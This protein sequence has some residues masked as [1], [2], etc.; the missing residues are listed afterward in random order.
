MTEK[1]TIEGTR[2]RSIES[3]FLFY[4]WLWNILLA[5]GL[6]TFILKYKLG[7]SLDDLLNLN[8][9]S[10]GNLLDSHQIAGFFGEKW[11]ALLL[12]GIFVFLYFAV[13]FEQKAA[14]E[15]ARKLF[16]EPGIPTDWMQ[17]RGRRYLFCIIGANIVQFL[18][19]A[20]SVDNILAFSAWLATFFSVSVISQKA[21]RRVTFK[22]LSDPS[23][24]PPRG[25]VYR[26]YVEERRDVVRAFFAHPHAQKDA[27][28]AA[29]CL[30]VA[31]IATLDILKMIHVVQPWLY[32]I[33][34]VSILTNEIIVWR[35]KSVRNKEIA[36][37]D[38]KQIA[39][40]AEFEIRQR[41]KR[42]R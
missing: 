4:H 9:P 41:R 10:L 16:V 28:L 23:Y 18:A 39:Y 25:Y 19:L 37:I 11:R 1:H 33:L 42:K 34:S 13:T 15:I 20:W 31:A 36:K 26:K 5:F 8:F 40:Q 29:I 3:N 12:S 7:I 32:G 35:W 14:I 22:Y 2:K 38:D 6:L 24:N 30:S 21:T 27:V 17:F